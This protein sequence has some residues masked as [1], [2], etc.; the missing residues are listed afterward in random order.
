MTHSSIKALVLIMYFLIF[1]GNALLC[2]SNRNISFT[3]INNSD[4]LSNNTVN[5]IAKDDLGFVWI[6]TNDG[7]CRYEASNIIKVFRANDTTI[8]G[9]I[10]SSNIRTLFLDSKSNLWIGTILGGLTRFHQPSNTWKTFRH[11]KNNPSSI[12]SDEIL[13]ITEDSKGRIWVG[14]EDG[15]NVFN[16]ETESFVSFKPNLNEPARLSGKAVLTVIEDDKGWIWSGT[17]AGGLNLL[18]P[19]ADG[20]IEKSRFRTFF[21]NNK[22]ESKHVWKILQDS[23]N[24]YWLGTRGAG[25]FLM[26]LPAE[27]NSNLTD[28]NWQPKFY[29]YFDTND[30][31]GLRSNSLEDIFEDKKGNLWIG[32]VNGASCIYSEELSRKTKNRPLSN[33]P[34]FVFQHYIHEANNQNSI[35]NN[36]VNTIFEDDQG[37][38][39]FGTFSGISVYNWF[40]NQ[41]DI[42]EF[43]WISNANTQNLYIDKEGIGWIGNGENGIFKYDFQ[44]QEKIDFENNEILL[45]G[46]VVS[47]ICSPDDKYLY[48]GTGNGVSK[49]NMKTNQIKDYLLPLELKKQINFF[50]IR[51]LFV[52]NQG[53]IWIGADQ[54]LLVIDEETG[55]YT[56][57]KHDPNNPKSI[58][59]MSINQIQ[60]DSNGDIW[61]ATFNGLNKVVKTPSGE[62]E[63]ERFKHNST[64]PE[65][66]IPS[67]RIIALEEINDILYIGSNSGLSGYNIKEKTFTNYSKANNKHSF[68]SLEKTDNGNIWGGTTEGI[69]FFNTDTHTFNQYEKGDGLGDIVFQT[70]SSHRDKNGVLYFGSR[71]GITRFNPQNLLNNEVPPAVY[72]T[73]IRT[74]SPG[75]ENRTNGTYAKEIVLEHNDYYLSLDYAAL[76]YNR[77]EKNK[78]AFMLEGFEDN[79]NYSDKKSP[80]IYTNLHHG[81]YNFKVKAANNDGVWNEEGV[82]LKVIKKPAFWETWWFRLGSLFFGIALLY[83]GVDFYT[84]NIKEKNIILQKYNEDLNKEIAQRK[85]VEAAL[86]EREQSLRESNENIQKYNKDLERSNKDLEQF[87]YIASHDLQE[88]LRVVG[89]F[90]GLLKRRY[91]QHFDEEAFQYIDFAVDGVSR[92]S[93]QIKSILT[94]SKVGQ[95]DIKFELTNLDHVVATKLHDLSQSIEEKNVQIIT[96]KMPEIICE[97]NQIEMVFHNLISNAIKFNK[98]ESPLVTISNNDIVSDEFWQF[99]VKDNGIGIAPEYQVQIFEIF[100]RL[101][102]KQDY[103]GTGI[104]L[105][106]CQKIIHRHGGE[107]WLESKEGEGTTFYFTINKNLKP[108]ELR[109]RETEL[110]Q[111]LYN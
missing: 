1:L 18:I 21:P 13:T 52:D 38:L 43:D 89:N 75:G 37:L 110:K 82:V 94:F 88:P 66:S 93:Q 102:N 97:K 105:A 80:A 16:Y 103:E 17:W 64:N 69:V 59:D 40:T 10:E 19:S 22:T 35:T 46:S 111:M 42:F 36:D 30:K 72:V 106:L 107:I 4:G 71:R 74:M 90:I 31:T 28:S 60:E 24:R 61:I 95:R 100:R 85:I 53:R 109:K 14:T 26:E 33:R 50:F 3:T 11:D 57:L 49:I 87:A 67:N 12:S 54:G 98:N 2:Q 86:Q 44:K 83:K 20:N 77:S 29:N 73:D 99:S 9:G 45:L 39:W 56:S 34:D 5:A 65:K 63:F 62:I 76:N 78:Y 58:S 70:G 91:K 81:T 25:L 27:A 48:I 55:N 23:Q 84:K 41:F 68:Q 92:M 96:D 15:L 7:L 8:D 79:W 32:T 104:G 51:S 108:K 47:A 6:G 101:H